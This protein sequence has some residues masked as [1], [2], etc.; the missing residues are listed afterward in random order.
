ML[1]GDIPQGH[2]YNLA[3][4]EFESRQSG[5]K[6]HALTTTLSQKDVDSNPSP[7][8]YQCCELVWTLAS[9]SQF[10]YLSNRNN[11]NLPYA[12]GI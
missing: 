3:E 9:E 12:H 1:R 8:A 2:S 4:S 6:A 5:P 10:P 7:S 11:W